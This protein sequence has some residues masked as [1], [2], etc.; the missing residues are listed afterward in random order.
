MLDPTGIQNYIN[1]DIKEFLWKCGKNNEGNI[2]LF[3]WKTARCPLNEGGMHIRDPKLD[4]FSLGA[5]KQWKIISK[6]KYWVTKFLNKKYLGGNRIG[7]LE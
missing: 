2:H 6:G 1:K 4:I 7:C 3:N 5:K